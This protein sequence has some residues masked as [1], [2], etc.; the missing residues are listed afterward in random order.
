MRNLS[1]ATRKQPPLT[2]A[3]ES[4]HAAAKTCTAKKIN[5]FKK[6]K[7]NR[8]FENERTWK[9]RGGTECGILNQLEVTEN[10]HEPG[11]TLSITE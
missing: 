8:I 11:T 10:C 1:T 9:D 4:P 5:H 7:N 2:T 3:R 6:R